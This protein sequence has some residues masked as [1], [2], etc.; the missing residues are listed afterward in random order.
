[1]SNDNDKK[2][3][4][5]STGFQSSHCFVFVFVC[6]FFACLFFVVVVVVVVVVTV[7][8]SCALSPPNHFS[9]GKT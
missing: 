3:V 7:V 2:S 5:G 4:V 9:Q 1:M 8:V 6:L